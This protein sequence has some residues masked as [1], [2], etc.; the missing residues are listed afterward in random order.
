MQ[1]AY[2]F[3]EVVVVGEHAEQ[4]LKEM[5]KT[6][7]ANSILVGSPEESDISLFKDR[8]VNGETFIYV[9]QNNTCKL[10]V[11]TIEAGFQQ[12]I[13]FGYKGFNDINL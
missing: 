8:F 5:N 1:Q 4:S 9:C 12:M 13:S 7:I 3:Y 10:P 11:K 2:P 6:F